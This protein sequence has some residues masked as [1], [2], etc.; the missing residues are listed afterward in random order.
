MRHLNRLFIWR[1][2][3]RLLAEK[4]QVGRT[5]ARYHKSSIDT[6]LRAKAMRLCLSIYWAISR[7]HSGIK[8]VQQVTELVDDMKLQI[9]LTREL[10]AFANF[11]QF[12]RVAELAVSLGRQAGG[13]LK[14]RMLRLLWWPH[15][16]PAVSLNQPAGAAR[17]QL[18]AP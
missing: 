10:N 9:Q 14:R 7:K 4:E 17:H 3:S 5:F 6:R 12:Q 8:L 2:A 16:P 1:D 13:W 18:K 15:S 11:A